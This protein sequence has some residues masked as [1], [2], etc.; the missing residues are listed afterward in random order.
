[1]LLSDII[2]SIINEMLR[3]NG[4]LAEFKRS[5]IANKSGCVPS[6]INYVITSRFTPEKG[7]IVE[8]RR[9]GGGFIKIKQI[10]FD[11]TSYVMHFINAVGD[12]VD[13][14]TTK[15][16]LGNLYNHDIISLREMRMILNITS[17]N[18]LKQITPASSRDVLRSSILKNAALALIE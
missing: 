10:R 13:Y 8:S 15:V 1:M 17:D 3:E 9:G 4:G 12:S 2:E 11:K 5:D 7:Y 18:I 14:N 16:F 6:Q